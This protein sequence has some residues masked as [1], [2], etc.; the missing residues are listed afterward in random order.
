MGNGQY[1]VLRQ[2]ICEIGRRLYGRGYI[3]GAEG[4][5]SVRLNDGTFLCTPTSIS[6]GFLSAEQVARIDAKINLIEGPLQPS[7]ECRM[8]LAIYQ[9]QPHAKAVVHAH[10]PYATALGVAGIAVP[11]D[12]L[13]EGLGYM[14]EVPLLAF[15]VPGTAELADQV[16]KASRDHRVIMMKNH[17]ATAWGETLEQAW[18]LME[19]LE[20]CC[21]V[22]YLT[23]TLGRLD[24]IPADKIPKLPRAKPIKVGK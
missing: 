22:T 11:M 19:V 13:A 7:S 21:K 15:E 12:M 14:G 20:S 18:M 3:S 5:I 4:N 23:R 17:G 8:H 1:Q 9:A 16:A 2:Q 10:P 24:P 6:K